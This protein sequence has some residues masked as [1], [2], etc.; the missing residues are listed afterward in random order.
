MGIDDGA[1]K[2]VQDIAEGLLADMEDGSLYGYPIQEYVE[3]G[4]GTE[5]RMV[6]AWALGREDGMRFAG[7]LSEEE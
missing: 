5:A 4:L 3:A 6:A 1:T 2:F 7:K